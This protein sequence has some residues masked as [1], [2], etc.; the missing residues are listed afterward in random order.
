M[1]LYMHESCFGYSWDCMYRPVWSFTLNSNKFYSSERI[2]NKQINTINRFETKRNAHT[3]AKVFPAEMWIQVFIL[4]FSIP[5]I[6]P[7]IRFR[8]VSDYY[9]CSSFSFVHSSFALG[10]FAVP[11]STLRFRPNTFS[12]NM[13]RKVR[14]DVCMYMHVCYECLRLF[15]DQ[16]IRKSRTGTTNNRN[17]N[18]HTKYSHK[19]D[20]FIVQLAVSSSRST[21][22]NNIHTHSIEI[23]FDNLDERKIRSIHMI[24]MELHWGHILY[25]NATNNNNNTT[26]I[27]DDIY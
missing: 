27:S 9:F 23:V 18:N 7:C 17:N 4:L 24:Y 26:I 1:N 11:Y 14:D 16:W 22:Y 21:N 10:S 15:F 6:A 2:N 20:S 3:A 25:L 8:C 13:I 12:I 19:M 5:P